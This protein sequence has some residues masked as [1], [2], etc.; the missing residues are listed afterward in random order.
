MLFVCGYTR[1]LRMIHVI[2]LNLFCGV[3]VHPGFVRC[4]GPVLYLFKFGRQDIFL[5]GS[6]TNAVEVCCH[7]LIGECKFRNFCFRSYSLVCEVGNGVAL[8][9][10]FYELTSGA[11]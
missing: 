10:R 2:T 4:L 11:T 7:G 6:T 1:T 8:K 3:F 5:V 9:R